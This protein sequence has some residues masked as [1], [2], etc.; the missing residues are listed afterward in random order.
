M[1]DYKRFELAMEVVEVFNSSCD[2][3][4]EAVEL[5]TEVHKLLKQRWA[6]LAFLQ[7]PCK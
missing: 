3:P 2:T 7:S 6:T 4:E 1:K 5:L